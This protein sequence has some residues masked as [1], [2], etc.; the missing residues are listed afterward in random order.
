MGQEARTAQDSTRQLTS[1]CPSPCRQV[2]LSSGLS[3]GEVVHPELSRSGKLVS[4][5]AEPAREEPTGTARSPVTLS[6]QAVTAL[7]QFASVVEAKLIKHKKGIVSKCPLPRVP[8]SGDTSPSDLPHPIYL[9]DEQFLLQRLAD[10]AIDLY[11]MVV[12][13]SR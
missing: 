4:S 2:G 8:L 11:T 10:G 6:L 7:E 9:T 5:R 12:V 1:H 13:L 3:L